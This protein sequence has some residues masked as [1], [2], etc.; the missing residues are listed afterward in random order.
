MARPI[1]SFLNS[2]A[3]DEKMFLSYF[4]MYFSYF[5]MKI[6]LWALLMSTLTCFVEKSE[7]FLVKK[8]ALSGAL[9]QDNNT[10][11]FFFISQKIM[12]DNSMI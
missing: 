4:S 9:E 2:I 12:L 5:S 1:Y 10:L 6:M 11:Y 8:N 3:L 7:N